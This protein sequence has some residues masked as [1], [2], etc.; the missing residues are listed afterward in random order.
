MSDKGN[1]TDKTRRLIAH[2][3]FPILVLV[4]INLIIGAL[5]FTDYGESWDEQLRYQYGQRSLAAYSGNARNLIDEKGAFY[6]MLAVLGSQALRAL[7]SSLQPIEA[8][9][10]IHFLS[11]VLSLVFLYKICLKFCGKW[12]AFGTVL[13]FNTQPVLWGHAFINPKDIPFMAFFLGSMAFGFDLVDGTI[14]GTETPPASSISPV[15][16]T[17]SQFAYD[18]QHLSQKKRIIVL[19]IYTAGASILIGL[20]LLANPIHDLVESLIRQAYDPT[21]QNLLANLFS[22]LAENRASVPVDQYIQKSEAILTRFTWF[23]FGFLVIFALT[24]ARLAFPRAWAIAYQLGI[25]PLLTRVWHSLRD[26]HVWAA[27]IFMGLSASIRVLGPLSGAL[28]GLYSLLK[29]R[30]KAVPVLIA[31]MA[32]A[33]LI[34]C[35]TWPYLWASPLRNFIHSLTMAS[36]YPWEGKVLFAGAEYPA[37]AVPRVYLPVLLGIQTPELTLILFLV[38]VIAAAIQVRR[39]QL[40]WQIALVA[41]LWFFAPLLGVIL[42]NPTMYDNFRQFLFIIPAAFLFIGIGLQFIFTRL[43]SP[44]FRILLILVLVLPNIFWLVKL[45]PYQYIYY[46]NIVGGVNG[47]FRRYDTDYWATSYEEATQ[48]L[49]TTAPTQSS[50]VVYGPSHI[51]EHYARPDLNIIALSEND[52]S[53]ETLFAVVS[54]RFDK[55]QTLY[56]DAPVVFKVTRDGATLVVVKQVRP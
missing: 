24:V 25:K 4:A 17:R 18:W 42:L 3:Y 28:V 45:H 36:D 52:Q 27:G 48:F 2:A 34:T 23:Y 56:P 7:N 16:E 13:L 37:S 1:A 21:N 55:D 10:F 12:A 50:V 30:W 32:I 26:V 14:R 8:W 20:I 39:K 43:R 11:F 40:D 19:A 47:A 38:G 46:N 5:I 22:R 6:V 44:I 9:H 54:T 53:A 49:N 33:V 29:A 35:L 31:Y 51:V 15:K 41:V